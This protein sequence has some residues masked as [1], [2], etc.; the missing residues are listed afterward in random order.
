MN[1]RRPRFFAAEN[2]DVSL[3]LLTAFTVRCLVF[4]L[5][6][7]WNS[8]VVTEQIL[9]DDAIG[10]HQLALCIVNNFTFCGDTFRTPGYPAFVAFFYFLFGP[11]PWIV[12]LAQIFVDLTTIFF[13]AKIGEMLFSRRAGIIAA[14]LLALDPTAIFFSIDL[15]SDS[16]FTAFLVA[17]LYFYL[18][19]LRDSNAATLA[20][21]G[22]VCGLTMLIRPAAQYYAIMLLVFAALWPKGRRL[23]R[24]KGALV[25]GMLVIVTVGPWMYRNYSHYGVAKI[26]SI[27]GENLLLWQ[28]S[29]VR[30]WDTG[31]NP[32]SIQGEYFEQAKGQGYAKGANP[33][34][35]EAIMQRIANQYILN[36]PG[37]Y[38]A[39]TL[40]GM[41]NTFVNLGTSDIAPKLGFMGTSRMGDFYLAPSNLE[42]IS[43]FVKTKTA[44]ELAIG[45]VVFLWLLMN[46]LAA[47]LGCVLLIRRGQLAILLLFTGTI[48][49]FVG[50]AGILGISRFRLPIAPFYLL[51]AAVCVDQLLKNREQRAAANALR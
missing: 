31:R 23:S 27:Q 4:L 46:Y 43:R 6:R 25:Y 49:Y 20:A 24:F 19:G 32:A 36:H 17:T 30:A 50:T 2:R 8:S 28:V 13:V 5:Y 14:L 33:F 16:L 29:Y 7:P 38:V 3:V 44:A 10:Y 42:L 26:S 9:R 47:F 12:L 18:R 41:F 11:R 45:G 48:L 15:F 1:W 21:A 40:R 35:N 34:K 22:C 51:M 39:R 37:I